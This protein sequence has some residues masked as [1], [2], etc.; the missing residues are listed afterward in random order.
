MER[1]QHEVRKP[2][3]RCP[4]GSSWRFHWQM[5]ATDSG[6]DGLW[7]GRRQMATVDGAQSAVRS[8]YYS[9]RPRDGDV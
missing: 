2:D 4:E 7:A 9:G 8:W 5:T 1:A 6:V 3:A